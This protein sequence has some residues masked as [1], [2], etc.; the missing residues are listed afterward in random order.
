MAERSPLLPKT[1]TLITAAAAEALPPGQKKEDGWQPSKRL[2][3]IQIGT[4]IYIPSLI[5]SPVV[6]EDVPL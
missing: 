4:M 3:W 5:L 2:R 1:A 6:V